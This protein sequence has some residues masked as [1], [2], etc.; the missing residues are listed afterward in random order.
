[1]K[2]RLFLLLAAMILTPSA[3]LM[4]D[5]WDTHPILTD[6]FVFS[7]GAF[8]SDSSFKL[9]SSLLDDINDDID[10]GDSIGVD[11][12]STLLNAQLRWK[13]GKKRKW[14]IW[15]QYFKN[16]A[17]GESVL[18]E[19]VEWQDVIFREG[20]FVDGGVSI[21]VIRAFVG[22]SFIKNERHDFGLGAGIHSLDLGAYIGGEIIVNDE[23]TDY[24]R[25]PSDASQ[26]L[27]NVGGWYTF[28]IAKSWVFHARVD[29]ISANVGDY[30]GTLWNTNV[31]VNFQAWR[32]V[33]FDLSYQYFD[34]DLKV[35][36][37]DWDGGARMTYSGPVIGMT[38]NW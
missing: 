1:M 34:L 32:H 22:R 11:K 36:K 31:G 37:E 2:N 33:G 26:I 27:P 30:D 15:G 24:R 3:S 6:N 25:Y 19:D 13:F 14:S 28:G 7:V 20:T 17:T 38:V 23:T 12:S 9:R 16:D 21:E 10:F 29:W 18:T 4:A 8:R 5:E 35:D